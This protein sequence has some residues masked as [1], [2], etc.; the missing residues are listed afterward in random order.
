MKAAR[1]PSGMTP[2]LVNGPPKVPGLTPAL[3]VLLGSVLPAAA[4]RSATQVAA[5]IPVHPTVL[6]PGQVITGASS[7]TTAML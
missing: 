5:A 1:P 6:A 4:R 3:P 2:L 7:S